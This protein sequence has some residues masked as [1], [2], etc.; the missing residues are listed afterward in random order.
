PS[1]TPVL[2]NEVENIGPLSLI[3]VMYM[4]TYSN[5]KILIRVVHMYM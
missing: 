5:R 4:V 2:I 3:S 1:G